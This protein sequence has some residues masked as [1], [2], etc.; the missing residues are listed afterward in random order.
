MRLRYAM[1]N[2][3]RMYQDPL[4]L[5]QT[6]DGFCIYRFFVDDNGTEKQNNFFTPKKQK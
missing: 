2:A 5:H 3:V 4:D 1:P 6:H